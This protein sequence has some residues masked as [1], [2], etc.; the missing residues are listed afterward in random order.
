MA[1]DH[2]PEFV[3]LRAFRSAPA[4]R[5]GIGDHGDMFF[6]VV[7]ER[8]SSR[9]PRPEILAH[10]P[11]DGDASAGH[12]LAAIG[13]AA[14]DHGARTRI[15]HGETLAGKA[16]C[17]QF[18]AGGAIKAGVADDGIGFALKSSVGRG[19]Q[20]DEPAGQALAD[21]IVGV[22]GDIE[23]NALNK[24]RAQALPARASKLDVQASFGNSVHAEAAHHMRGSARADRAL[25][26]AHGEIQLPLLAAFEERFG[27]ADDVFVERWRGFVAACACAIGGMGTV[28]AHQERVEIDV[29]EMLGAAADLRDQIGAADNV[30]QP[31]EAQQRQDFAHLLR[32]EGHQIDDLLRR[33]RESRAQAF[34]LCAYADR[35]S[36]GMALPHHETAHRHKR[37]RADAELFRAEDGGDDDVAPGAQAAIGAQAHAVAHIVEHQHLVGF[38]EAKLPRN[39]GELDRGKRA[40]AGAPDMAR[41]KDGVGAGLGHTRRHRADARLRHQFHAHGGVGIDLLEIVNQLRQIFDRVDVVVR[42]RRDQHDPGRRMA[43]ARDHLGD[44]E[45]GQLPAFA[46]L[47]ALRHLDLEFAALVEILSGDAEAARGHLLDRGIRIVAV[48]QLLVAGGVLA[49]FARDGARPDAVHGDVERAVSLGRERAQAHAGRHEA[50]ADVVDALHLVQGNAF[51]GRLHFEQVAQLDR[52]GDAAFAHIGRVALVGIVVVIGACLLQR[53]DEVGFERMRLAARAL[54]VEAPDRQHGRAGIGARMAGEG[55]AGKARET[56]AGYS[57]LQPGKELVHQSARKPDRFEV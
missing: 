23:P 13:A 43:Q 1:F 3:G 7:Q 10:R 53:V 29:V 37:S 17:V 47:G 18:A 5:P 36:V 42:R 8:Q 9:H 34:V 48:W 16:G 6:R 55:V 20:G 19:P 2:R 4:D 11:E 41:D 39:A 33:A 12:V 54:T 38:S 15:A 51:R 46:G 28:D 49:A 26:V 57:A 25:C 35:A 44:L 21:I 31:L 52:F 30:I 14:F 40:R 24:E 27:V 32:D 56:D 45:A 22:A 50:L